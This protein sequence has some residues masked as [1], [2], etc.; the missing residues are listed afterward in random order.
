ML[1]FAAN[2]LRAML[3]VD[4]IKC[5]RIAGVRE[6]P[7]RRDR[8]GS[9]LLLP[10]RKIRCRVPRKMAQRLSVNPSRCRHARARGAGRFERALRQTDLLEPPGR[11]CGCWSTSAFLFCEIVGWQILVRG[12]RGALAIDAD[13]G[14][15]GPGRGG[16]DGAGADRAKARYGVMTTDRKICS[17]YRGGNS[18]SLA[19]SE[20][21]RAERHR[22]VPASIPF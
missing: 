19:R 7:R 17:T 21:R 6:G 16:G 20:L 18:L 13:V 8:R 11:R 10:G 4:W 9:P 14:F 5:P 2:K 1:H 3:I 15:A 12:R 22:R